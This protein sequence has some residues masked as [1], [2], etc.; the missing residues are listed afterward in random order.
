MPRKPSPR[1]T[2]SEFAGL[3]NGRISRIYFEHASVEVTGKGDDR[4]FTMNGPSGTHSLLVIATDLDRLN[5]HW[6]VFATDGRNRYA[7]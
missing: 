2:F 1:L 3:Q 4:R 5:G 7:A 6:K